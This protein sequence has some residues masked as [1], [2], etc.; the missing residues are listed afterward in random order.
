MTL[1]ARFVA[2]WERGELGVDGEP[3]AG[4]RAVW[5]EA[6]RAF[7]DVR[8]PGG[9]ASDTT[10]AGTTSWS[11]PYL[12]WHRT[13]DAEPDGGVDRGR[14]TFVGDDLVEEGEYIA[15]R[16]VTYREHWHRLEGGAGTRLAAV[17]DGGVAVRVG[18][19]A[20]VVVDLRPIGGGIAARY[21]RWYGT[22][23]QTEIGFGTEADR[24][25]L[26]APLDLDTGPPVGWSWT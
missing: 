5:V 1:P 22:A 21:D 26:P 6:G 4:G 16:V 8:G 9:F 19:H 20:A 18:D 14:I 17:T 15:G 11:E 7:V 13:V 2:A 25:Q 24:A 10:F 3:V 12:T 23:W